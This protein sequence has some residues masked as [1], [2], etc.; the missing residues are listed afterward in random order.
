[1][2]N[3]VYE[4][5]VGMALDLFVFASVFNG[6]FKKTVFVNAIRKKIRGVMLTGEVSKSIKN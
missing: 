2:N 3:S 1:M 5:C 6:G 4:K